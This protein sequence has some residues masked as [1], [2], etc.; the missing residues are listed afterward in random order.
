[1]VAAGS[2]RGGPVFANLPGACLDGGM[3][4]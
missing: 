1:V 3:N 2:S 4:E